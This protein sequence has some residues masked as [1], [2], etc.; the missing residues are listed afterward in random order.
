MT[1]AS[2]LKTGARTVKAATKKVVRKVEKALK[3]VG[4]AL[5]ITGK[6]G[7]KDSQSKKSA[8]SRRK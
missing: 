1:A 4:D 6:S 7:P 8:K 2:K 3:P 5:H